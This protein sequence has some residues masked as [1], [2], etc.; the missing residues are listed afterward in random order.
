[1]WCLQRDEATRIRL[2]YGALIVDSAGGVQPAGARIVDLASIS[3]LAQAA[4]TAS[5]AAV[6]TP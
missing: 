1:M 4:T 6:S 3:S 2:K 5:W